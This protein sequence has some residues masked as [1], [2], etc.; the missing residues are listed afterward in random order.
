[1]HCCGMTKPRQSPS[2]KVLNLPLWRMLNPLLKSTLHD[3]ERLGKRIKDGKILALS[4]VPVVGKTVAFHPLS[5]YC[6][7]EL[8]PVGG[9]EE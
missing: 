5:E 8:G 9:K 2:E 3:S 4:L 6:S 1:M 7:S